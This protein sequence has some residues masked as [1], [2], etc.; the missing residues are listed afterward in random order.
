MGRVAAICLA[1]A[2]TLAAPPA[3]AEDVKGRVTFPGEAPAPKPIV[4]TVD[5]AICGQQ[6]LV[7]ETL[8]VSEKTRGVRSVVVWVE[9]SKGGATE[10]QPV[11]DNW[12]CRYEPH[13]VIA[14]AGKPV[15]IRN[16]DVFLHTTQAVRDGGKG[17]PAFNVAMPTKGFE[18]TKTFDKPGL[19][20]LHCDVHTWMK[21]WA[22][23]LVDEIAAV[24]DEDGAFTLK[25]LPPGKHTLRLWHE[26]L[27]D[28]SVAIEVVP[29]GTAE[30]A[31]EWKR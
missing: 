6:G 19:Y 2:A 26:A 12:R 31:I 29:E 16:R 21:G 15:K 18:V 8:V 3:R 9:G 23:V 20:A 17:K 5:T 10:D 14:R 30:I 27:G 13:V 28:K 11:I 22:A 24:T 7:E 25:G 1:V 4:A